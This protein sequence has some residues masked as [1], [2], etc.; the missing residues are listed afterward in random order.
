MAGFEEGMQLLRQI[1]KRR[2]T[3]WLSNRELKE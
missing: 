2:G 3:T 1:A